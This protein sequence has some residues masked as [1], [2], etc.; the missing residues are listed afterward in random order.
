MPSAEVHSVLAAARSA[1]PPRAARQ[2][3]RRN[4]R[5]QWLAGLAGF[6]SCV[7][8]FCLPGQDREA[9][10]V[11]SATPRPF[12]LLEIRRPGAD[13]NTFTTIPKALF[14]GDTVR[15]RTDYVDAVLELYP[16]RAIT[17]KQTVHL[18]PM[19]EVQV[20]GEGGWLELLSGW[21]NFLKRPSERPVNFRTKT[22]LGAARLTDFMVYVST[23]GQTVV[24]LNSGAIELTNALDFTDTRRLADGEAIYAAGGT[25]KLQKLSRLDLRVRGLVQTFLYYPAVLRLEESWH[26]LDARYQSGAF[27]P[28]VFGWGPA[29]GADALPKQSRAR[30]QRRAPF[31]RFVGVDSG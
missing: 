16:G 31:S 30:E 11:V 19:S 23:N 8:A 5:G 14:H 13:W 7:G 1:P 29:P 4:A 10:E 17:S 6:F 3:C 12:R 15:T 24:Y 20:P 27:D 25:N 21:F 26:E 9:G 2:V 18:G 28:G 22:V